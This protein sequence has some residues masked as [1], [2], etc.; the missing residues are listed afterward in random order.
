VFLTAV[1][2]LSTLVGQIVPLPAVLR[3]L[4]LR[5]DERE[6]TEGLRARRA[7]VDAALREVDEVAAANGDNEPPGLEPLR[8]VLELRRDRITRQL[9]TQSPTAP[10]GDGSPDERCLRLRLLN[11]ERAALRELRRRGEIGRRTLV[12]ISHE[13]DLDETRLLRCR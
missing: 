4:G 8:Q 13:L 12:A 6:R 10:H 7:M 5:P 2:V 11:A 9:K 1:V 3:W